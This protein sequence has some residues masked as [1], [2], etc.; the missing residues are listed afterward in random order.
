[1]RWRCLAFS[2]QI[3]HVSSK[4]NI[5]SKNYTVLAMAHS[6]LRGGLV[7]KS[8]P[9]LCSPAHSLMTVLQEATASPVAQDLHEDLGGWGSP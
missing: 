5:Q 7:S 3:G 2:F 1:M 4:K 8:S 6:R 9:T